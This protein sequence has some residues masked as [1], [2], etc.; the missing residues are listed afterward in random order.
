[1]RISIIV[2]AILALSMTLSPLAFAEGEGR[3]KLGTALGPG[4]VISRGFLSDAI[5]AAP[6]GIRLKSFASARHDLPRGGT[7]A[8][9]Q[10][11]AGDLVSPGMPRVFDSH[12]ARTMFVHAMM[13]I[14]PGVDSAADMAAILSD[15]TKH[16]L[17]DCV[18]KIDTFG[19]DPKT[20]TFGHHHRDCIP[21]EKLVEVKVY[22]QWIRAF[23][24]GC[25]NPLNGEI[26][27][28]LDPICT[29]VWKVPTGPVGY[30]RPVIA[31]VPK[32]AIQCLSVTS[33]CDR[34][35]EEWMRGNRGTPDNPAIEAALKRMIDSG[36]GAYRLAPGT[37][38]IRLP[39]SAIL[40]MVPAWCNQDV[41]GEQEAHFMTGVVSTPYRT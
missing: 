36:G 39:S 16:R 12:I 3:P 32:E 8:T 22:G 30:H 27:R 26:L 2:G 9:V 18:G 37:T 35:C 31:F 11:V 29:Q 1:M 4:E 23:S 21:G 20:G 7:Q 28:R 10:Q 41:H 24:L 38:E 15:P 34:N 13:M 17:V 14:V 5:I 33:V 19:Y 40:T 6:A 25:L